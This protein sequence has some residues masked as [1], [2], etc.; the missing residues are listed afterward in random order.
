[1]HKQHMSTASIYKEISSA[2][3][4]MHAHTHTVNSVNM[5]TRRYGALS[6]MRAI[7]K[8]TDMQITQKPGRFIYRHDQTISSFSPILTHPPSCH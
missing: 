6:S 2:L 7:G 4:W 8:D 3:A 1:M 5:L